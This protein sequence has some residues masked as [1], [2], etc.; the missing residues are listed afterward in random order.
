M[1][2]GDLSMESGFDA[3]EIHAAH[4]YVLASFLC[5]RTNGRMGKGRI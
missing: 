2:A 5:L 3:I 1:K 4:G